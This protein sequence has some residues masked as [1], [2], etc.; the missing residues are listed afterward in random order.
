MNARFT[1]IP[2]TMSTEAQSWYV[3]SGMPVRG[4]IMGDPPPMKSR[5]MPAPSSVPP[6]PWKRR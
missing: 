4:P 3:A 5:A 1:P 6:S 2:T